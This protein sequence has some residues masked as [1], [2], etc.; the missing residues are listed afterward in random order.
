M[1]SVHASP[2]AWASAE[3]KP[4]SPVVRADA[5]DKR[6]N[7]RRSALLFAA[8]R[9]SS[10]TTTIR[11]ARSNGAQRPSKLKTCSAKPTVPEMVLAA[12]AI[13]AD[14]TKTSSKLPSPVK[15]STR[16]VEAWQ[17]RAK[18]ATATNA[19]SQTP[20]AGG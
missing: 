1:T 5:V 7:L 10:P 14:T 9:V 13:P 15:D 8:R 17:H 20:L 3:V 12:A 6:S 19:G 18:Q 11:G 2:A 16:Q 4:C